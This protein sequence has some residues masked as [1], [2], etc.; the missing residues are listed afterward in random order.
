MNRVILSGNLTKDADLRYTT[1][2]KAYSKFCIANNEGYGENKNV[3]ERNFD[4]WS[5]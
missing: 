3:D 4:K 5:N 1:T 2:E